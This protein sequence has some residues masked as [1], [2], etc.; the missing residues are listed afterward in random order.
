MSLTKLTDNLNIHQSLSDRPNAIEGYIPAQL[1][2]LYDKAANDIKNHIN[3]VLTVEMDSHLGDIELTNL[4]KNGD[5]R[6]N[7]EYWTSFGSTIKA[8]NNKVIITGDGTTATPQL[9]QTSDIPAVIGRKIHCKVIAR[10]TNAVCTNLKL[11][12][13]NGTDTYTVAEVNNPTQDLQYT[14]EDIV[15]IGSAGSG[16]IYAYVMATYANAATASGKIMEVQKVLAIDL[17]TKYGAG[18]EPI[19]A[20]MQSTLNNYFEGWFNGTRKSGIKGNVD[21]LAKSKWYGKNIAVLGDSVAAGYGLAEPSEQCFISLVKNKLGMANAFNYGMP[22]T[23]VATVTPGDNS[24]TQRYAAMDNSADIILISNPGYNDYGNSL[25]LNGLI[26]A[27]FGTMA[28]RT[29]ISFYGALHV[30]FSGLMAKYVGKTIVVCTALH[31][32]AVFFAPGDDSVVNPETGKNLKQYVEAVREVAEYYG[33]PVL[34]FY[35]GL[36]NINP[37]IAALRTAYMPDGLHP[38]EEGHQIIANAICSYLEKYY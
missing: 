9:I 19:K 23:K 12:L 13:Y 30:L 38:N 28:D 15:T 26:A 3:N 11:F 20:T 1:K 6:D 18:S 35:K 14:L 27:P 36:N 37:N 34:D 7:H 8:S 4:I 29:D 21:T 33:L 31:R 22:S 5:F 24:F 32:I 25:S 10:V 17:T 2:I 16:T